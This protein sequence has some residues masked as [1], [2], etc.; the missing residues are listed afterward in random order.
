MT[1]QLQDKLGRSAADRGVMKLS[2]SEFREHQLRV[3]NPLETTP[4]NSKSS[5]TIDN[6]MANPVSGD[7]FLRKGERANPG[8]DP[9]VLE[10]EARRHMNE[11]HQATCGINPITGKAYGTRF[12]SEEN[13]SE[14]VPR[15]PDIRRTDE[16]L[17]GDISGPRIVRESK[18]PGIPMCELYLTL[19]R[20]DEESEGGSHPL[21]AS[22]LV[23]DIST[24]RSAIRTYDT[25]GQVMN[26][27]FQGDVE[28][29]ISSYRE[30]KMT[31]FMKDSLALE[32]GRDRNL[33]YLLSNSPIISQRKPDN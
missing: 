31:V 30:T 25:T 19:G 23:H 18:Q 17:H 28:K 1:T 33:K 10:N 14:L 11:E 32:I 29:I 9:R 5:V 20:M 2:D 22:K 3:R 13:P 16:W 27:S 12:V 21:G 26:A 6:Y 7:R 24:L 4:I 8:Y 15:I